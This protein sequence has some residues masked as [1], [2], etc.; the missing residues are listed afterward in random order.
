MPEGPGLKSLTQKLCLKLHQ[1]RICLI[2]DE[3]DKHSFLITES[4]ILLHLKFIYP[5]RKK[6]MVHSE[7]FDF[8]MD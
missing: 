5:M 1:C 3:E 8:E 7:G 6:L 4:E 2:K